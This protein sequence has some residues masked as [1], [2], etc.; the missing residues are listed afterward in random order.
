MRA[1]KERGSNVAAKHA[2]KREARPPRI[3]RNELHLGSNDFG[4]SSAGVGNICGRY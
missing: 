3:K 2:R 1:D 4:F